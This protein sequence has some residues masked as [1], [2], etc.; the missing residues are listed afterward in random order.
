M[1]NNET[2]TKKTFNDRFIRFFDRW[3]PNAMVF[4]II[5]TIIVAILAIIFTGCPIIMDSAEGQM[6]LMNSWVGGFWSLLTFGMQMSLIMIT[7]NVIAISPP[8]QKLIRKVAMLPN[9]WK[10]AF[11]LLVAVGWIL[12][13]IHWGIGMM[14]CIALLRN[15]LAAARDKGYA[16]LHLPLLPAPTAP[17]F[18]AWASLRRP[19]CQD[20]PRGGVYLLRRAE[21]GRAQAAAGCLRRH[22]HHR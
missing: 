12:N 22:D 20:L 9:N 17:P 13:Y 21:H 7:G 6:S 10:Q 16:V 11:V 19:C 3:T 4:A 14:A 5:L 1:S 18:P 2:T 15:V 8:V